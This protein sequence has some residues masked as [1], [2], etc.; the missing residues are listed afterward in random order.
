M[1]TAEERMRILKMIEN[2]QISAADG[3]QLLQALPN[4]SPGDT[5]R[6]ASPRARRLRV[7]VSEL[8]SGKVKVNV[9][10]P[11]DLLDVG[12]KMGARFAPDM[13]GM[14]LQAVK[15]AIKEGLQGKVMDVEDEEEDE[16]VEVFVE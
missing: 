13:A 12:L 6:G 16:R 9:N 10:V 1:A 15:D 3:T 14:D 11:L 7:Q 5:G 4:A 8:G 2:R